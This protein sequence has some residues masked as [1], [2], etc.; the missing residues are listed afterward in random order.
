MSR[1]LIRAL[2]ATGI[3]VVPLG[4]ASSA[5]GAT[6]ALNGATITYTAAPD[7]VNLLTI[8]QTG[9]NITFDESVISITDGDGGAGCTVTAGNAACPQGGVTSIVINM[10]DEDDSVNAFSPNILVPVSGSLG[11]GDDGISGTKNNDSI[12]G[13]PGNDQFFGS[14]GNDTFNGGQGSDG[15]RGGLGNDVLHGNDGSD[16]LTG[17]EGNDQL[18]GDA[19]DDTLSN[20]PGADTFN[21]GDGEDQLFS[22]DGANQSW[23]QNGL[24]DDGAPGEGDNW[25]A[26]VEDLRLGDGNNTVVA[27][28]V[29]NQIVTGSGADSIDAGPG[30]DSIS[31]GGGSDVLAGGAGDDFVSGGS[32]DDVSDGGAG[33]DRV[34]D[35]NGNDQLHGGA[36]SDQLSGGNGDDTLDGG[37]GNDRLFLNGGA[38][39]VGGG[40]D[41][42]TVDFSGETRSIFVSLDGTANDGLAGEGANVLTDVEN[43]VGGN[44]DD[45][46]GGSAAVNSID[47]GG[48][49][50]SIAVRDGSADAVTCGA[51]IDTVVADALDSIDPSLGACESVDR[52][53]V[54]GLGRKLGRG[55]VS[56]RKGRARIGVIC[57]LDA[58]GGCAGT[59][60]LTR[61]GKSVASGSYITP[62]ATSHTV[63]MKLTKSVA[64][65]I[66][67]GK[68]VK[69]A[70]TITGTDLRAPLA[71]F[72]ATVTL[73]R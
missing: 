70:V 26:D 12:D 63:S 43:I 19:G 17:D 48:G 1:S 68:K 32:G 18:S 10:G 5:L 11:D 23:T 39:T 59:V 54:A 24:A 31:A 52:G 58:L 6:V 56:V 36:D 55:G 13:G 73:K 8:D 16:S 44:S 27:G 47:G 67:R 38:D 37:P 40:A 30:N 28:A 25:G 42:D 3:C 22:S 2:L 29:D 41:T 62:T 33:N 50:D 14:D 71:T 21:G 51:G 35:G 64:R 9:G 65:L 69:V 66:A 7:E 53:A 46:L 49:N 34:F 72:T 4:L 15:A 61:N 57:P 60:R 45:V 20:D